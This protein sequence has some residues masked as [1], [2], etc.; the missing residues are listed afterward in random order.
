MKTDERTTA[1]KARIGKKKT[2]AITN[3][4]E[5]SPDRP[6]SEE[7]AQNARSFFSQK[8]QRVLVR[9]KS[10]RLG[11]KRV[12]PLPGRTGGG[13]EHHSHSPHGVQVLEV[14]MW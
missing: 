5:S 14:H 4:A 10:V 9:L 7:C 11:R 13:V 3:N 12:H 2:T 1:K 8:L 6:Q